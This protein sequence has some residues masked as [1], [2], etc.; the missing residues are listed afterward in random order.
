MIKFFKLFINEN[1]KILK[2]KITLFFIVLILLCLI[3]MII[4]AKYTIFSNT[5]NTKTYDDSSEQLKYKIEFYENQKK[6]VENSN[7]YKDKKSFIFYNSFLH[8]YNYALDNN[9]SIFNS[10]SISS[11][12]YWKEELI[13]NLAL[14]R[15]NYYTAKLDLEF[16]ISNDLE[17]ISILY[18]KMI[19]L[20]N[21]LKTDNFHEFLNVK[22]QD[23]IN[24]FNSKKL[25]ITK[26]ELDIKLAL[27]ELDKNKEINRYSSPKTAWKQLKFQEFGRIISHL[28]YSISSY[29]LEEQLKLEKEF[30]LNLYK[31]E[32]DINTNSSNNLSN[33]NDFYIEL[34]TNTSIFLL[35]L[36]ILIIA[37]RTLASEFTKG[38]IKQLL[39]LPAK[40]WKILLAKLTSLAFILLLFSLILCALIQIIG[41]VFFG[42]NTSSDYVYIFNGQIKVIDN[43]LYNF[44]IFLLID[45]KIFIYMLFAVMLSVVTK[46]S[47]I[48]VGL[49]GLLYAGDISLKVIINN[50]INSEWIKFIPF[51]NLN[52]ADKIFINSSSYLGK[53]S[54]ETNTFTKYIDINFS[55]IYIIICAILLLI[56]AFDSFR[57]SQV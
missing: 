31:I 52:L 38:T 12:S 43:V 7:N 18:D 35:T 13:Q 30:K 34:A 14:Q 11:Q 6:L 41:N 3:G 26:N 24:D 16:N 36:Y 42:Y 37:S 47:A 10:Y 39:L 55:I 28:N 22:K 53:I 15:A 1:T 4:F 56:T 48:C 46:N 45:I 23:L 19:Y 49:S 25:G 50:L 40:R 32:N 44:L 5:G 9:I 17:N 57:K 8:Y 29:N 20:E 51:N 33:E 2:S 54:F 21:I 27:I